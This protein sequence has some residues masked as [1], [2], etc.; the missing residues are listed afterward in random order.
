MSS[1]EDRALAIVRTLAAVTLDTSSGVDDDGDD[2]PFVC[3]LCRHAG[4]ADEHEPTCPKR[5]ADELIAQM[6]EPM[7]ELRDVPTDV[8]AYALWLASGME[9]D[10]PPV[11]RETGRRWVAMQRPRR[12]VII[13]KVHND[14]STIST[15]YLFTDEELSACD[16]DSPTDAS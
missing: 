13:Y 12:N 1:I 5:L 8:R 7:F 6:E 10:A 3:P 9:G 14:D 11:S 15:G 16:L 2:L 4:Y